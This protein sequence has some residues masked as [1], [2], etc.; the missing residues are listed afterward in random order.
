MTRFGATML[1]MGWLTACSAPPPP[2]PTPPPQP[3]P[4]LEL[5]DEPP[6]PEA[7]ETGK[8]CV[9]AEAVCDGG[10]CTATLSNK[11]EAPVTCELE[12]LAICR[13]TT[14]TGE[15]RGKSRDTIPAGQEYDM[16]AGADC[17]G[18]AVSATT[19]EVLSCR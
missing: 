16:Q 2:A 9:S 6:P 17:Q 19:V 15:A 1:T 12:V 18:K 3:D 11:C 5:P 4:E 7:V 8:D 13:G 10:V 14:D